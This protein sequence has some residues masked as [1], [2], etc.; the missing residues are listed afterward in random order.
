[1]LDLGFL[2]QA[3]ELPLW[4]VLVLAGY[5]KAVAMMRSRSGQTRKHPS[6]DVQDEDGRTLPDSG[7]R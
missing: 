4:F 5:Q 3:V 1:M 6:G 2:V 7:S